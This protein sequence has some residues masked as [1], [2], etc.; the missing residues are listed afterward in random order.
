MQQKFDSSLQAQTLTSSVAL[1]KAPAFNSSV[2]IVRL[3]VEAAL[4]RADPPIC[5][6]Q[7]RNNARGGDSFIGLSHNAITLNLN[8]PECAH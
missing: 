7:E 2:T 4:F 1:T 6:K 8:L 5:V 3:F